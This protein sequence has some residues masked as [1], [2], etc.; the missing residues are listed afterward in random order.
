MVND[1]KVPWSIQIEFVEGCSRLCK[2]CGLNGIRNKPGQNLK[3]MELKTGLSL[4]RQ[5]ANFM[6]KAR[7]EFAMHGEPT[8]HPHYLAL[9]RMFRRQLPKTQLQITTNGA[10]LLNKS[11][12]EAIKIVRGIFEAGI[13]F[14]ILDTYEPER[15]HLQDLM[16]SIRRITEIK[17]M[18]F[19]EECQDA[20]I[21]PWHNHHRKLK[22]TIILMDDLGIRNGETKSRVIYNHA[23]N[24]K[25]KPIVPEP[26]AKRCTI[27]FREIS[28]CWNGDVCFC[29]QDW[30]HQFV[31]G[32]ITKTHIRDIWASKIFE[33]GRAF[34]SNKDRSIRPCN[35]CDIGSGSRSGLVAKYPLPTKEQR[36]MLK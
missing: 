26:L 25:S 16:W 23:G 19:Y 5:V 35:V 33:A 7:V 9:I 22:D 32:N 17:V 2:F 31:I 30:K 24:N 3:F 18:D 11:L 4:A 6:P 20:G 1:V 13:D 15:K 12:D 8:L 21:S 29:C 10:R 28:V 36:R 14:M 27:P 34:L